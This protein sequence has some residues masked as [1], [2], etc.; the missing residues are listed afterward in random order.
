LYRL[1]ARY[2]ERLEAVLPKFNYTAGQ[3]LRYVLETMQVAVS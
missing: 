2:R 1:P 3:Q